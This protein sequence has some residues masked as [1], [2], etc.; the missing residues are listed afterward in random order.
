MEIA[1]I[2]R[3]ITTAKLSKIKTL[4]SFIFGEEGNRNRRKRLREFEGFEIEHET[5][6]YR[7]KVS[8]AEAFDEEEIILI[9]EM[10][11]ITRCQTKERTIKKLLDCLMDIEQLEEEH[12]D[13]EDEEE[14]EAEVE[15]E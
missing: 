11:H 9:A 10:L 1:K 8:Q 15:D 5:E 13:E 6:E 4:H 12:E 3:E 7:N 14:V 2:E